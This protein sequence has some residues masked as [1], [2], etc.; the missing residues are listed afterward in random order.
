MKKYIGAVLLVISLVYSIEFYVEI[1][2]SFAIF[3]IAFEICKLIL[4][5]QES[6]IKT[7]FICIVCSMLVI[8]GFLANTVNKL[9]V[10]QASQ[11]K[12]VVNEHY[13]KYIDSKKTLKNQVEEAKKQVDKYPTFDSLDISQWEDKTELYNKWSSQ[14]ELLITNYNNSIT[15]LNAL[16][17]P[18]KFKKVKNK[19][20]GFDNIIQK[21]GKSKNSVT[22]AISIIIAFIM[23]LLQYEF[24][25][26]IKIVKLENK[27]NEGLGQ[28]DLGLGQNNEGLGQNDL[29]L[30]L[31]RTPISTDVEG[32]RAKEV[33]AKNPNP[34]ISLEKV[35]AKNPNPKEKI[36]TQ[37]EE[38]IIK[39]FSLQELINRKK[40]LND[41]E[42]SEYEWKMLD[43]SKIEIIEKVGT[44]FKRVK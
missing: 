34:I 14:K 9:E 26:P 38:Y 11:Y 42:I 39:N 18:V 24:M 28:N 35:R 4:L 40:I 33:R 23:E 37:I 32:V 10:S 22:L 1:S 16:K 44:K 27:V 36:L 12:T 6:T 31:V 3:I 41:L 19:N 17:K 20:T 5:R 2:L 25:K 15:K 21:T 30:G 13:T 8:I 7:K 43:K 29:G